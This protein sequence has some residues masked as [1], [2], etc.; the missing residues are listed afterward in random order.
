MSFFPSRAASEAVPRTV[1]KDLAAGYSA[2]KG[3]LLLVDGSGDYAECAADP[4]AIAAVAIGAG[5]ADASG[6]NIT[7]R[8]EFPEGKMQG[9]WVGNGQKFL[10]KY[11]GAVGNPG[12]SYGVIRDADGFWKVDFNETVA[13]RV[14]FHRSLNVSPEL[15]PLVEVSFLPANVTQI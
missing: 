12:S 14:V 13:T 15:Q 1:E 10:A 7:G 2:E 9:V 6:F 3:A 11:V 8:H 4:A 5:G